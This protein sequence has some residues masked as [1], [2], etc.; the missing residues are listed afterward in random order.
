MQ[1]NKNNFRLILILPY[2][3][4]KFLNTSMEVFPLHHYHRLV[5]LTP[6]LLLINHVI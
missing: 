2:N 4:Y 6:L 5:L 1:N 3:Y